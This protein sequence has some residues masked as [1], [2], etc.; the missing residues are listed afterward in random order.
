MPYVA[1]TCVLIWYLTADPKLPT[2]APDVFQLLQ[3]TSLGL[4]TVYISAITLVELIYLAEKKRV[5]RILLDQLLEQI[6]E[7]GST[8]VLSD[9]T[10]DVALMLE[11]V[12]HNSGDKLDM[13]DRIIA[14]HALL[15]SYALFTS[16]HKLQNSSVTVMW[17]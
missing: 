3:E 14:A 12:K 1:D 2:D 11:N 17:R 9:L 16:D 7:P 6:T 4:Q 10:G 5:P 8:F 15:Q 13:P